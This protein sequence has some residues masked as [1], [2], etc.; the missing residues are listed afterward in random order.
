MN[1]QW[2]DML[3]S[4]L[5]FN[6]LRT[7][8]VVSDGGEVGCVS[9]GL[10]EPLQGRMGMSALWATMDEATLSPKAHMALLDGPET[11]THTFQ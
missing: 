11:D 1:L 10:P 7:L 5:E 6:S 4:V 9:E 3:C 2:F 8:L